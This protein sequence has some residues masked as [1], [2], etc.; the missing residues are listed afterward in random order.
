[1]TISFNTDNNKRSQTLISNEKTYEEKLWLR[2]GSNPRSSLYESDALPLG[3]E[4]WRSL[5]QSNDFRTL[6]CVTKYQMFHSTVWNRWLC[7]ATVARLTP[8]QKVACSNHVGVNTLFSFFKISNPQYFLK[9]AH[10]EICLKFV[11]YFNNVIHRAFCYSSMKERKS[12]Q[13]NQSRN[14]KL[15]ARNTAS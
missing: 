14:M 1:M 5:T 6:F 13:K 9:K 11:L 2:R 12:K 8:D 15:C 3:H 4:A 10:W 7:G